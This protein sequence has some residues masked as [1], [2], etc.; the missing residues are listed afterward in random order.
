MKICQLIT[1][2]IKLQNLQNPCV[3]G[4][5]KFDYGLLDKICGK[6]KCLISKKSGITN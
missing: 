2:H 3:L 4:S 6:I 1:F 5:I